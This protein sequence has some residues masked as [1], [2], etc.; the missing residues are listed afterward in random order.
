MLSVL[1]YAGLWKSQLVSGGWTEVVWKIE[2]WFHIIA[3]WYFLIS[4]TL[5]LSPLVVGGT[6]TMRKRGVQAAPG[7][8]HR[9]GSLRNL[10]GSY[11]V[12][13]CSLDCTV[14]SLENNI[15]SIMHNLPRA[16][17]VQIGALFCFPFC[18]LYEMVFFLQILM[19]CVRR[20]YIMSVLASLSFELIL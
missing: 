8:S 5:F 2:E 15:C 17:G 16:R 6:L 3:K 1:R 4:S 19:C 20:K 10:I 13:P 12:I 9:L 14:G 11:L 18:W 7:N